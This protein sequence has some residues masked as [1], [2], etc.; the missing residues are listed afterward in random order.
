MVPDI[1][2]SS[3]LYF[4]KLH[5]FRGITK[6]GAFGPGFVHEL[7][8]LESK[9]KEFPFLGQLNRKETLNS[10]I[11]IKRKNGI[12]EGNTERAD[13]EFSANSCFV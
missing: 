1:I 13:Q 2:S 3:Y 11:R 5:P 10:D 4:S 6:A 7:P 12:S 8:L 9:Y